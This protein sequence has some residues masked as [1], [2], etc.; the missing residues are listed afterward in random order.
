MT[1]ISY[2][3][4]E[5]AVRY[6]KEISHTMHHTYVKLDEFDPNKKNVKEIWTTLL[7]S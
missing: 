6:M 5:K 1:D 3:T 4:F 2:E 7:P